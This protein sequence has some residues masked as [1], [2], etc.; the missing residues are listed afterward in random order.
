VDK[1]DAQLVD[2]RTMLAFGGGHI[3]GALNIAATPIL[4]IWAGWLLDPEK[5]ILLVL[6]NESDLEKVA[7]LFVRTGYTKFAGYL[8]GGMKA[9]DNAGYPLRVLPQ[10]SVHD[11]NASRNGLQ[12]L[13]VRGPDEWKHGHIPGA[14]HIFLPKLRERLVE[15]EQAKPVLVYCESGYRASLAGSILQRE[16]FSDVRNLP[17]SWAAWKAAKF[18]IE[19]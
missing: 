18:P 4:S 17:G 6:E 9:W 16:G 2:T 19:K 11:V 10:M 15:L 3:E 1:K 7:Q 5:P 13:D 14:R 8:V 12:L